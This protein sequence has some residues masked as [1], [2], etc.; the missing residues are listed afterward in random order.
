MSEP[1]TF[2]RFWECALDLRGAR[3]RHLGRV[4]GRLDCW[5]LV[6]LASKQAGSEVADFQDYDRTPDSA[7]LL[8]A[9][10]ERSDECP[11]EDMWAIGR[12]LVIRPRDLLRPIHFAIMGPDRLAAEVQLRWQLSAVDPLLVHSVRR[13]HGMR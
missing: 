5:G 12:V 13:V 6:W 1:G 8:R 10:E 4:P 9:V 2:E 3:F 7:A 11:R